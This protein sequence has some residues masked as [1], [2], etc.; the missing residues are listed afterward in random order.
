METIGEIAKRNGFKNPKD[1]FNHMNKERLN[2]PTLKNGDKVI[3]PNNYKPTY[4]AAEEV[5]PVD[6]D[7]II[8]DVSEVDI[9]KSYF[10]KIEGYDPW[11]D[12]KLF[13]KV[14]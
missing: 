14:K 9:F 1:F 10:I 6:K 7:L 12:Y 2:Y 13:I 5:L 11:F 3:L 8:S 4:F